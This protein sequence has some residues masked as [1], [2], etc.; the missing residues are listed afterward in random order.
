VN[1][2]ARAKT[3]ADFTSGKSAQSINALNTV[4]GHLQSL[5]EAGDALDNSNWPLVN[6]V[7]NFGRNEMGDPRIKDFDT[8]KKA[9]VDELTRVWR[10]SG[11]S[12]GDIKTWSDQIN[13]AN[14]PDQLHS[15]VGKIGDLLES[16][17][18]ALAETYK[19]GM[20]TTADP[21]QFV[22]PQSQAALDKMRGTVAPQNSQSG[23]PKVRKYNPATGE[24]E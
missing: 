10:G 24:L 7:R 4:I 20:G 11:G 22:T 19:Q 3:R 16:K 12:E 23:T 6:S 9:V 21:I 18:N 14:S 2:N 17:I 15:V 1:Y 13:S 8:T 5:Q